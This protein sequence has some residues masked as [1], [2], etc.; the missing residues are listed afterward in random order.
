MQDTVDKRRAM[1]PL[2]AGLDWV[3]RSVF[4]FRQNP[5][6]WLI[7]ALLYAM[8][9]V[10]LPSVPA[11]P[12]LI[13]LVIILF[14]PTFL[15]L[16]MGVFREADANRDTEPRELVE[17]IKPNF[18][19]LITLG[20]IFL[21]YGILTGVLVKGEVAALN[22]LVSEKAEAEIVMQQLTPLIIKML[23]ILTPMIMASWFS[24][25]LVGFHGFGVLEAIK[26][27]F[28]QCGRLLL[29]ITVAWTIL[30]LALLLVLLLASL[31][32][33]V[34][35]AVSALL[36]TLLM[37]LVVFAMLLLVT[38]FLLAIQYFSYRHVY[39]RPPT[40]ETTSPEQDAG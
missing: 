12:V 11:L 22:T 17:E 32:V 6:K 5:P 3:Y 14:W 25:M 18:V 31:F 27:S 9:F 34:I 38:Y 20:G 24:P 40:S 4:L 28:W 26:H 8:L 16:F 23:L 36:G 30:G 33:G 19:R 37:S 35:T 21:A 10:M 1:G 7:H 29:A 15:A 13:S 2:K 39:Y